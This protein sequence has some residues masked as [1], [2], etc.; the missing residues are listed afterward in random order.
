MKEW[1]RKVEEIFLHF[2]D[3][4]GVFSATGS[5]LA[6]AGLVAMLGGTVSLASP[7]TLTVLAGLGLIVL[8]Y[9][10]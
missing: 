5:A 7:E 3:E 8:D 6:G 4:L 10:R 1:K 9:F 2:D